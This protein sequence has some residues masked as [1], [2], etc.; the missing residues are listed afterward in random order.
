MKQKVVVPYDQNWPN[1]FERICSFLGRVDEKGAISIEHIGSTSIPGMAA[2]PIIDIDVIIEEGT[3]HEIKNYLETIG[4]VHEGDKGLKGREAFDG[5]SIGAGLS[6]HH[7]YVGLLDNY[8]IKKHLSFRNYL[9]KNPCL[10][11]KV[12]AYKINLAESMEQDRKAY[13]LE[14][15]KSPFIQNIADAAYAEGD[16]SLLYK[17]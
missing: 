11:T 9:I 3:F 7:L 15:E 5:K 1:H 6:Y 12:G 8:H 2:K 16:F 13:Q 4:Y 17:T 14:K 10:V